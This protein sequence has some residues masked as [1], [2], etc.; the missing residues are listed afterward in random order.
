MSLYGGLTPHILRAVP[1]AA[2]SLGVYELV[3]KLLS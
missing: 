3:L 1:S 2:I